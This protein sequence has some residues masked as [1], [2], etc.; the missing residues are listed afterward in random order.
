MDTPRQ[1]IHL[2]GC[3]RKIPKIALIKFQSVIKSLMHKRNAILYTSILLPF[4]LF[5]NH[6][7]DMSDSQF[8]FFNKK[9]QTEL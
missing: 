1:A 7:L 3:I 4:S 9:P 2:Y 8:F 5:E 6:T